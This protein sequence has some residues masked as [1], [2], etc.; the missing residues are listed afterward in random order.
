M[1]EAAYAFNV[2][3]PCGWARHKREIGETVALE[4]PQKAVV[5]AETL[6]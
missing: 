5:C 4:A 6:P 2:S 1:M 3:M